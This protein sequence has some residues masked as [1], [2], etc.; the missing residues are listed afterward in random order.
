MQSLTWYLSRLKTMSAGEMAWRAQ[1]ALRDAADRIRIPMKLYP[2]SSARAPITAI[3]EAPFRLCDVRP[4]EWLQPG[5]AHEHA[6]LPQLLNRADRICEH[7]FR[8]FDLEDAFLG[9]PIEWNRDHSAQVAAP[10]TIAP[11][12]DYRDF[13]VTGDCKLVW[14]P[15]RHHQLVVLAR[16]YRATGQ[17]QY[18]Y[19]VISQLNSWI[20]QNPAGYGMNWRS[21]LELAIRM[22]NW[23]WA[24]DLIRESEA[25]TP[26][27]YGRLLSLVETHLW[28]IS[29][30]FS[31]GT[32]AN[33]HL[34]G[35][36][37][38]VFIASSYFPGLEN[39]ARWREE[40]RK[41]LLGEIQRQTYRDGGNR[42]QAFGY[43]L[44]VLQF[45]LFTG[46]VARA[47]GDD[48]PES[49]WETVRAM[50]YFAGSI[51][52]GGAPAR[53]GD[54]DDGYVLDLGHRHDDVTGLLATGA[55][56]F[57]SPELALWAGDWQPMSRWL[58][59]R[60]AEATFQALLE[61][62]RPQER[63]AKAL[64][65]SG[66]YLLQ[67]GTETQASGIRVLFDCGELGMGAIAA[68]GHADAL[69][70]TLEVSGHRVLVDPG[71]YDYFTYPAW[72]NYFRST[73]AHNTAL[74]DGRDQSE[75]AGS[76]LW[77]KRAQARCLEFGQ[78]PAGELV[79]AGDHD[80]YTR[81]ADPVVH[82]RRLVMDP[83]TL[84]MQV[85]DEFLC[86]GSHEVTLLY[87]LAPEMIV[88]SQAANSCRL[89]VGDTEIAME[90]DRRLELKIARGAE[91]PGPGW[92][93]NSY[94]RKQNTSVVMAK[95]AIQG[96]SAFT[97][98]FV[99]RN[100][101]AI[102]DPE[103]A[104]ATGVLEAAR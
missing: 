78:T 20:G 104:A 79:V 52:E 88:V 80:G 4:G 6:W 34:I 22:I 75:M 24:I 98:R 91:A 43:H 103:I 54:S 19:E 5:L 81:L 64:P 13:R 72:R 48:L 12:I 68:H 40:S 86:E 3:P 83:N 2:G 71:T 51:T 76:F 47:S 46:L 99:V 26:T 102:A 36:A 1:S 45:A 58:L 65:E 70:F 77:H 67:C 10:M 84:S 16:A 33:N 69:S 25:L 95:A 61:Q 90:L 29:R 32:S 56:L 42:E 63:A 28:D 87:H 97:T 14:E 31:R 62:A 15:N 9:D 74:V 8:L 44:F 94:H 41:I 11:S 96:T 21:P 57:E 49:Y 100:A 39:A 17:E 55:V 59:G 50:L 60:G 37:A 30:K 53:Y 66:L 23:V 73:A 35:E 93:S 92:V 27:V 82:R 7:R 85:E 18:S 101:K 89:Q 38:G